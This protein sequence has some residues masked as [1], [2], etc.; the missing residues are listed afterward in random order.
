MRDWLL[1]IAPVVLVFYFIEYPDQLK[2]LIERLSALARYF[3]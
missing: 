2:A 1:V 3:R